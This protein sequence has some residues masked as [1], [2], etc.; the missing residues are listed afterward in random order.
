MR[1]FSSK[2]RPS[3]T[4]GGNFFRPG[5]GSR[6]MKFPPAVEDG[7]TFEENSR[8]KAEHYS[9]FVHGDLVVAED[10]RLA[11]DQLEGAP[12]VYSARYDSVP[13]GHAAGHPNS[14]GE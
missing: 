9:R 4:A 8:I 10:S 14:N 7:R 1:A 12:R 5:N 2:V 11:V 6:A 3:S 13:H